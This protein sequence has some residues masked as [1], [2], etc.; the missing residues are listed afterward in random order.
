[1]TLHGL[2]AHI[3]AGGRLAPNLGLFST[4]FGI[5]SV[6]NALSLWPER[7]LFYGHSR[8]THHEDM[9]VVGLSEVPRLQRW[10]ELAF[11]SPNMLVA[12]NL[13][14]AV[15]TLTRH[16][17]P[18]G[19]LVVFVTMNAMRARA[20]DLEYHGDMILRLMGFLLIF[21]P[22][23]SL[24]ALLCNR[25]SEERAY[26]TSLA[27]RLMQLQVALIYFHALR[28]KLMCPEWRNLTAL[29]FSTRMTMMLRF[30]MPKMVDKMSVHKVGAAFTLAAQ[31]SGFCLVW[32]RPTWWIPVTMLA[33]L[34][35]SIEYVFSI[36]LFT[37]VVLCCL[38]LFVPPDLIEMALPTSLCVQP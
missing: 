12:L 28:Q 30:G 29:F 10:C 3:T 36:H 11:L 24:R 6:V 8:V 5:L 13:M 14:G 17:W 37:A 4:L 21:T 2:L 33:I 22:G 35:L 27:V 1:M 31:A 25:V 20:P 26:T 38:T 19:P 9:S 15:L 32:F 16:A 34:H 7:R 18:A 23:E